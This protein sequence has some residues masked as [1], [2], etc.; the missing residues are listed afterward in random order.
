MD[1]VLVLSDRWLSVIT[2]TAASTVV[3]A[4]PVCFIAAVSVSYHF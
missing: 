3:H 4:K 2:A 1:I